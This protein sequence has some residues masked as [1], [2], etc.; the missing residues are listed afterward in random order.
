M[1]TTADPLYVSEQEQRSDGQGDVLA[2]RDHTVRGSYIHRN[3]NQFN[4]SSF[5]I[6]DL[7]SLY[8]RS[9]PDDLRSVNYT[10]VLSPHFFIEATFANRNLKFVNGGARATDIIDGT[11][12]IDHGRGNSRYWSPTFCGVCGAD[13]ERNNENLVLERDRISV[14]APDRL[15]QRGVRLR[16][17]QR[18]PAGQ[19]PSVRQRLSDPRHDVDHSRRRGLP[20]LDARLHHA[21]AV[22]SDRRRQ[23]R[24][25]LPDALA[26]RERSMAS[27]PIA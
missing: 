26:V 4:T 25:R 16:H 11:L 21:A 10:G 9:L 24:H 23:P 18:H 19:E 8:D 6:L 7:R 5:T 3:R 1:L 15:A 2:R 13:E 14:D 12:V 22:E 27:A 20:E 17:V